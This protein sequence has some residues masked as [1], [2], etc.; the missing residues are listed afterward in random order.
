M[1]FYIYLRWKGISSCCCFY[2]PFVQRH[3]G[4]KSRG[5]KV[6]HS[7]DQW[8]GLINHPREYSPRP[9]RVF[10]LYHVV[11]W[12]IQKTLFTLMLWKMA[13]NCLCCTQRL[14]LFL[15]LDKHCSSFSKR[16]IKFGFKT[17]KTR[18]EPY[19]M[20][21]APIIHFLAHW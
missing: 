4:W 17:T 13:L 6:W 5:C 11:L 14:V 20:I 2:C 9:I 18:R 1:I 16:E 19:Y 8:V 21:M 7:A 10:I 12:V 15:N 3:H